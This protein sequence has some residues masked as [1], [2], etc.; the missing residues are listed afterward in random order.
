MTGN[1]CKNA[2][3]DKIMADSPKIA[4]RLRE[5][6]VT[7]TALLEEYH[8]N[9]EVMSKAILS[10]IPMDEWLLIVKRNLAAGGKKHRFK[11][12]HSA[13]NKGRKGISYPGSIAT[14]FQ[15]GHI[16]GNA[17]RKYRPVG[18]IM[19]H[20]DK[21]GNQYRYIKI[22]GHGPNSQKYIPLARHNWQQANGPVPEGM[23]IVHKDGNTLNDDPSNLVAVT[24][25]G[26][27]QLQQSRDPGIVVR[28]RENR[29]KANKKPG[30]NRRRS[31]SL[32]ASWA[33]RLR[34]M[35]ASQAV[36]L[37]ECP[38]CGGEFPG[39]DRPPRCPKCNSLSILRKP[40]RLERTG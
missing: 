8:C 32:R 24:R 4:R 26:H 23:F 35:K 33:R 3:Y 14:Q 30:V 11:K 21:S 12:G 19:I 31:Q 34:K 1:R 38:V 15:K 6:E 10:V 36:L 9:H 27:V 5:G 29:A 39:E 16:R 7:V 2:N 40:G 20:N 28:M 18:S 37:W 17:A 25:K 22:Q 13:W